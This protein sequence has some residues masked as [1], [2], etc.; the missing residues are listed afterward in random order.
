MPK[1]PPS[2][3]SAFDI[4][5]DRE[6]ATE[7]QAI[8]WK[9]L[10]NRR[11]GYM[12]QLKQGTAPI[13]GP[14][15]LQDLAPAD[16]LHYRLKDLELT[17]YDAHCVAADELAEIW[18]CYSHALPPLTDLGLVST[19]CTASYGWGPRTAWLRQW[20]LV[21]NAMQWCDC[22]ARGMQP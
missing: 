2:T 20:V 9:A 4:A 22:P 6:H 1:L 16:R 11:R 21:D 10:Y 17:A 14:Y 8:R 18:N 13:R 19:P 15:R 7:R 5:F 3:N 12:A